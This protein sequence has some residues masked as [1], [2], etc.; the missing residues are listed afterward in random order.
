MPEI[1]LVQI[2]AELRTR[3]IDGSKLALGLLTSGKAP[4]LAQL[5][6][7]ALL[8]AAALRDETTE[9]C[10][11]ALAANVCKLASLEADMVL[12]ES[13]APLATYSGFLVACFRYRPDRT[14]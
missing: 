6:E 8:F 10:G 9:S 13:N 11:V 1:D 3:I 5:N 7:H 4:T 12:R 2:Q 14:D